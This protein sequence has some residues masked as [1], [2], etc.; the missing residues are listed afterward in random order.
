M[1]KI[2]DNSRDSLTSN[3]FGEC[4]VTNEVYPGRPLTIE[5]GDILKQFCC[6]QYIEI[7][8]Q[9]RSYKL[10]CLGS[11]VNQGGLNLNTEWWR[12]CPVN[13]GVM[14]HHQILDENNFQSTLELHYFSWWSIVECSTSISASIQHPKYF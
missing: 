4:E 9:L 8:W 5:L 11:L 3:I 13:L 10:W 14:I 12:C 7:I 6:E 1:N 2:L